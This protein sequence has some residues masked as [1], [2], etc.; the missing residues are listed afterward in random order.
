MK[1]YFAYRDVYQP[2]N[3][4]LKEF[5]ADSILDFF[6]KNW[7]ILGNDEKYAEFLGVDVYGFPLTQR[8]EDDDWI[9]PPVPQTFDDLAENLQGYV[10][11]NEV[12]ASPNCIQV[13]TDDDEVELAWYVFDEH[14]KNENMDKVALWFYQELPT[15]ITQ[16]VDFEIKNDE[17]EE[18]A[19]GE[20]EENSY[21]I[22]NTI[23]DSENFEAIKSLKIS[24]SNLIELAQNLKVYQFTDDYKYGLDVLK[25]L[26]AISKKDIITNNQDL[27]QEFAKYNLEGIGD[28]DNINF[29]HQEGVDS[30]KVSEHLI[31]IGVSSM[32]VFYNY[33]VL[34]DEKW[35]ESYPELANSLIHFGTTWE[36]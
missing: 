22:A 18:F 27:F 13:H 2:T 30:I 36:I 21:L 23:Y 15:Q 25:L 31:E 24:G 17:L 5:E 20:S 33:Y 16:A 8:T 6:Q 11:S 29:K 32:G 12:L 7:Q 35:A 3:R 28:F 34:F 19:L 9:C 4:F 26:K 1:I 10:Y 14:Y